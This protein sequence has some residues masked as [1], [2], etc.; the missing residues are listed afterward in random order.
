MDLDTTHQTSETFLGQWKCLVSTTN[1][2]KG[3]IICAWRRALAEEKAPIVEYSDDAW[4][5][6]VGNVTPQHVGRLRRVFE[7]FGESRQTYDGLYWS[8]FQAALDWED[9]E[10]WLEG[11]VQSDWSVAQMRKTRWE[12]M[13]APADEKPREADIPGA[14]LDE[15][16]E[17]MADLHRE[18]ALKAS[19]DVVRAADDGTNLPAPNGDRWD[20]AQSVLDG[21]EISAR[22]TVEPE[23]PFADL[24]LLP[25]DVTDAFEAFTLCILR[26]RQAGWQEI[27]VDGMLAALD[28]LKALVLAPAD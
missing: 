9:A 20:E 7:R 28:G 26:H 11:A 4:S 5:H 16:A 13:G 18:N 23:R 19:L 14:E 1:W 10:M 24:P 21:D 3:R 8:H 25:A 22:T 27:S 6:R 2:E 12:A 15:D 17:P